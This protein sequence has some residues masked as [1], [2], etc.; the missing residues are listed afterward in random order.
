MTAF[1]GE[2][3]LVFGDGGVVLGFVGGECGDACFFI[4]CS[5][6]EGGV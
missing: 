3:V 6:V 1:A 4:L 2:G 5:F